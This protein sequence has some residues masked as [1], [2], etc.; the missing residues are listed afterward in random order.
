MPTTITVLSWN[1]ESLGDTKASL[2]PSVTPLS[3]SQVVDFIAAVTKGLNI[4][5]LGIMEVKSGIGSLLSSWLLSLLNNNGTPGTTWKGAV[6]SRQDGGTQE[7]YL[8][9]WKSTATFDLN[10]AGLPGPT[11]L[12]NVA[13]EQAFAGLF[14][15]TTVTTTAAQS[16]FLQSLAANGYLINGIFKERS[17]TKKTTTYRVNPAIWQAMQSGTP[18]AF[19]LTINPNPPIAFNPAQL[20]QMSQI[21]AQLDVLRFISY[22]D[23]SPYLINLNLD[24]KP[25]TIALYHAPGPQDPTRFEA[26]NNIGMSFPLAATGSNTLLMGDFN[27]STAQLTKQARAYQRAP[28]AGNPNAVNFSAKSPQQLV[29]VYNPITA[30]PLNTNQ[31]LLPSPTYTSLSAKFLPN[32][33]PLKD[34][35]ANIYDNFYFRQSTTAANQLTVVANSAKIAAP[36]ATYY[37]GTTFNAPIATL[38]LT[39]FRVFGGAASLQKAL[40]TYE[41]LETKMD[42]AVKKLTVLY[43]NAK[44][45]LTTA[46]SN[47]APTGTLNK[48]VKNNYNK[49]TAANSLLTK[50]SGSVTAINATLTLVKNNINTTPG[51]IGD[52]LAIYRHAISDHLPISFQL[53]S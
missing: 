24:A 17:T 11:S 41:A 46:Q 29:T 50:I 30:A 10:M 43:N 35:E 52:A 31:A 28:V 1:I 53:Q 4:D 6:S 42:K 26:I 40:D 33:A 38:L 25:L 14:Q 7:Q 13:D 8:Y 51:G 22:G 21:L 3:K 23:R 12:V 16:Q 39:F 18:V 5:V 15:G 45:N 44:A 27:I 36:L 47:G 37:P 34:T 2:N 32:T 48:R 9:F 49:L 19:N 20:S